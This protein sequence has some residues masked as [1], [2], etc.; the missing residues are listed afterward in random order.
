MGQL[1]AQKVVRAASVQTHTTES[2]EE[3][4]SSI[5]AEPA[6]AI[7][8]LKRDNQGR[9]RLFKRGADQIEDVSPSIVRHRSPPPEIIAT[10][11]GSQ[12]Q[13]FRRKAIL[14]QLNEA[15]KAKRPRLAQTDG[16]ASS[17]LRPRAGTQSGYQDEPIELNS[18]SMGDVLDAE[19]GTPGSSDED[20]I[21]VYGDEIK[22]QLRYLRRQTF[23]D[24][25]DN[26]QRCIHCEYELSSLMGHC[27][28]CEEVGDDDERRTPYYEVLDPEMGPRPEIAINEYDDKFMDEEDRLRYVGDY[29]DDDS[30]AY[31]SQDEKLGF[32]EQYDEADSFIDTTSEKSDDSEDSDSDE[33]PD[34]E[35]KYK[36]LEADHDTVVAKHKTLGQRH[37]IIL[38][39]LQQTEEKYYNL[40]DDIGILH[41]SDEDD[42]D[43]EEL[44]EEID[45]E[46]NI[47]VNPPALVPA[48]HELVIALAEDNSQN[49][50]LSDGRIMDRVDAF[51]AVL[52]DDQGWQNISLLSTGP[53]HSEAEIEL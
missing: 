29:L 9:L 16:P 38:S 10:S 34:W 2:S 28:R 46:G 18:S 41:T 14:E 37:E 22:D 44:E 26:V 53:N 23:Y 7:T 42:E 47:L 25:R 17:P 40:L 49:S 51:E 39:A 50:K 4:D 31:D 12:S 11:P 27:E 35:K 6:K 36:S 1:Q 45:E 8:E 21:D 33:E 3:D 30:S 52:S 32:L 15:R 13:N 48:I 20:G 19:P 5:T 43:D 24:H